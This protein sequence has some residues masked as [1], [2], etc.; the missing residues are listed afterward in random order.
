MEEGWGSVD[1]IHLLK[2]IKV[3]M[4]GGYYHIQFYIFSTD[5]GTASHPATALLQFCVDHAH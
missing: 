2:M 1:F 5:S 3:K 4:V